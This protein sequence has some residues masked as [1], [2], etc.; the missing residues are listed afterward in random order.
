MPKKLPYDL[1]LK[2]FEYAPRVACNLL[3]VNNQNEILLIKRAKPPFADFWHLPGSF[4]L[5]DETLDDCLQRVA[6]DELGLDINPKNAKLLGVF[7]D[8][9]KDPR[10]HV[11]DIVYKYIV[12][13]I[14]L[15]II[16]DTKEVQ[17]F[18][19]LPENIGFNHRETLQEIGFR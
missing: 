9:E 7:E 11:I 14:S 1:F 19:S 6:K 15:Q 2:S 17:F 5:K 8:I 4:L 13:E 18:S 12:Q 3:V 16:G 10:G